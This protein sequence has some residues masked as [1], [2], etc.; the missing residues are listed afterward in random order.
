MRGGKGLANGG[1]LGVGVRDE[2]EE[3]E[4]ITDYRGN[5]VFR[6]SLLGPTI[7]NALPLHTS[8]MNGPLS[9][10]YEYPCPFALLSFFISSPSLSFSIP[11]SP[12]QTRRSAIHAQKPVKIMNENSET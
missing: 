3:E 12:L 8:R 10:L 5:S 9:S 11:S 6:S 1:L 2:E 4:E 7:Q